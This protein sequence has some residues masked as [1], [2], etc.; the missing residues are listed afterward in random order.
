MKTDELERLAIAKKPLPEFAPM[1]ET[2]YYWVMRRLHESLRDGKIH[3]DAAAQE[4][5]RAVRRYNEFKALYE[6]SRKLYAER[7]ENIRLCSQKMNDIVKEPDMQNAAVMAFE[8][9]GMLT[10]DQVFV[11]TMKG[12]FEE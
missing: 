4:K 8:V 3:R 5:H 12:R 1:H 11:K 6:E 2:C 9:I 10:G 7:Q